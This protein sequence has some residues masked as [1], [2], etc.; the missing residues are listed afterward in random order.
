MSE[1]QDANLLRVMSEDAKRGPLAKPLLVA[2]TIAIITAVAGA[3]PTAFQYYQSWEHNIPYSEVP[4]RLAQ[5]EMFI[6][7]VDCT[8]SYKAQTTTNG[9]RIDAAACPRTGDISVRMA[10]QDGQPVNQWVPFKQLQKTQ[11]RSASWLDLIVTSAHA[12]GT[13]VPQS[14]GGTGTGASAPEPRVQLAQGS[15]G[16]QVMCQALQPKSLIVRIVNDGGKCYR[17][18]ISAIQGKTERREEVPCNTQCPPSS[19]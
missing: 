4:H 15:A 17:E 2:R 3:L 10:A 12:E 13:L 19:K 5:Y 14:G 7:N 1:Q 9:V 18:T 6:S 8:P 16:L 11:A